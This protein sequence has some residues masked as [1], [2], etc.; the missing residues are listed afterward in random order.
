MRDDGVTTEEAMPDQGESIPLRRQDVDV[1]VLLEVTTEVLQ[2]QAAAH[3]VRL[4]IQID[5]D[6]PT[7][8]HV[9]RDKVAWAISSLVGSALRHVQGPGGLIIVSVSCDSKSQLVIGVRDNGPGI[10]A[11]RLTHLL[12][13]DRWRPG[14]ALALLL[15]EEIAVAHGGRLDV[16]S[17]ADALEHFT[18][19]RMT[20]PLR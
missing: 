5:E 10:S 9:D 11:E 13:R 12:R 16:E 4:D 7:S 15:V 8:V 14:S 1:G 19:V 17:K 6:V 3:G 2:R 20:I 18:T